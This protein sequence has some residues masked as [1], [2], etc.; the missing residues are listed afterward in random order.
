MLSMLCAVLMA[1]HW[2]G[3]TSWWAL[4]A[5]HPPLWSTGVQGA[6]EEAIHTSNLMELHPQSL[7][8]KAGHH[9]MPLNICNNIQ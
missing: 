1:L 4:S 8:L 6:A 7:L 5:P 2:Y 3:N 9:G